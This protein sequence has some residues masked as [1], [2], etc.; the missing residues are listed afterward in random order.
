[1]K[2]AGNLPVVNPVSLQDV[3]RMQRST[4][5]N[6]FFIVLNNIKLFLNYSKT[7]QIPGLGLNTEP[8]IWVL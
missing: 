4:N 8:K 7:S 2:G 6:V 3:S 5:N 1:M